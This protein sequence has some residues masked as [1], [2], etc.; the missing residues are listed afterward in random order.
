[1]G[2]TIFIP[3]VLAPFPEEFLYPTKLRILLSLILG[4]TIAGIFACLIFYLP[5]QFPTKVRGTG[6]G[7]TFNFGR[8]ITACFPFAFG[9]LVNDGY[10]PLLLTCFVAIIPAFTFVFLYC[11]L[12]IETEKLD[13]YCVPDESTTQT[14]TW[15]EEQVRL[16]ANVRIRD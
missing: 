5:E 10:D 3:I 7:F 4:G 6:C 16:S 2:S 8:L 14:L 9:L 13:L 11:G 1:M 12:V 15:Y